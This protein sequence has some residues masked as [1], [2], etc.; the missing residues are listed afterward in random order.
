MKPVKYKIYLRTLVALVILG[1]VVGR[2][3]PEKVA[4]LPVPTIAVTNSG[5]LVALTFDADM[6]PKMKSRLISGAVKSYDDERVV[7]ILQ[8]NQVKATFFLTGMW[9]EIYQQ[10]AKNIAD[11]NLFEI[12]NH[13]YSHPGFKW[14]CYNLGRVSEAQKKQEIEKAEAVIEGI[15]GVRS[16]LWRFPGG[17]ASESDR[18]LVESFGLRVVGWDF[19]SSDA[20]NN[21]EAGIEKRVLAKVH[22]GAIIVFHLG[23][24]NSPK[25]AEALGVIIPELKKR[26]YRFVKVSELL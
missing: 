1:V 17:C 18:K 5:P 23:G 9:T 20:F 6:T 25:T 13:S 24:P 4:P 7:A 21:N 11:N 8:Q 15:T 19:G 14:P 10:S 12:G 16:T 2:K 3:K 26:G 22:D